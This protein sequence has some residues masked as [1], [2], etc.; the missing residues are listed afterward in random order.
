MPNLSPSCP[1]KSSAVSWPPPLQSCISIR[2]RCAHGLRAH[3][4]LPETEYVVQNAHS[5]QLCAVPAS[6][7]LAWGLLADGASTSAATSDSVTTA[8]SLKQDLSWGER[9]VPSYLQSSY[10]LD[11]DM[12]APGVNSG[13]LLWQAIR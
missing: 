8:Q 6:A 1:C 5:H 10:D 4:Q 11:C 3:A 7:E 13:E 12:I 9:G 2:I